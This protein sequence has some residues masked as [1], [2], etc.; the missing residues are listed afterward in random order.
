MFSLILLFNQLSQLSLIDF[1]KLDKLNYIIKLW[2]WT[3]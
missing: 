3:N 2:N 1:L